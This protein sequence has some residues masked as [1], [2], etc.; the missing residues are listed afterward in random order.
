MNDL[1]KFSLRELLIMICQ[2]NGQRGT[3]K[4]IQKMAKF[5]TSKDLAINFLKPRIK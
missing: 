3:D 4:Q 1:K 2:Y 5:Y